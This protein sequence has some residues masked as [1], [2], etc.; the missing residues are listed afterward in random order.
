MLNE[1]KN[2]LVSWAFILVCVL[3]SVLT[4]FGSQHIN[5]MYPAIGLIV[6][7]YAWLFPA[8]VKKYYIIHGA[9]ED[10]DLTRFIPFW[11][12]LCIFTPVLSIPY[13]ITFVGT[14]LS[15]VAVFI[16]PQIL[17]KVISSP[18]IIYNW[19]DR[20]IILC[21]LFAVAFSIVRGIGFCGVFRNINIADN[22]LADTKGDGGLYGVFNVILYVLLFIPIFR[23]FSILY[24]YNRLFK[25]AKF[26]NMT[27]ADI[28]KLSE[29]R[30]SADFETFYENSNRATRGKRKR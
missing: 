6:F 23:T 5:A 9:E 11:N 18:S 19:A 16:N 26:T 21:M 13:G 12:E 4:Y 29:G 24:E 20:A 30:V 22:K 2:V 7:L 14:L 25:I 15:G 8:F 10:V 28:D 27:L 17:A 1:E 3:V